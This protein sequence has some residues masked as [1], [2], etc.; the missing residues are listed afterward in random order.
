[1]LEPSLSFDLLLVLL[2]CLHSGHTSV[3]SQPYFSAKIP[4]ERVALS[5]HIYYLS[6]KTNFSLFCKWCGNS[7]IFVWESQPT[8][9][10]HFDEWL[11][12]VYICCSSEVSFN[13]WFGFRLLLWTC[14]GRSV[15]V[16]MWW[17]EQPAVRVWWHLLLRIMLNSP[18]FSMGYSTWF[19]QPGTLSF[20]FEQLTI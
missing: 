16:I 14:C 20:M 7:T 11:G 9:W 6:R 8:G 15:A 3:C 13:H 2:C 10:L 1:M 17:F 4:R 5:E 18:M 12:C 19:H